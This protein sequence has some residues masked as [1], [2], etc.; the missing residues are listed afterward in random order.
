[1]TTSCWR[2]SAENK[3]SKFCGV[4]GADII[5]NN[6]LQSTSQE[7]SLDSRLTEK[8]KNYEPFFGHN[9][10]LVPSHPKPDN[11]NIN[12][13]NNNNN[14]NIDDDINNDNDNESHK[15]INSALS[16]DEE[17]L[18]TLNSAQPKLPILGTSLVKEQQIN[19]LTEYLETKNAINAEM[20]FVNIDS[21]KSKSIIFP[22][23]TKEILT[24]RNDSYGRYR[25]KRINNFDT[26]IDE[27]DSS[28]V[29]TWYP[30]GSKPG[31]GLNYTQNNNQDINNNNDVMENFD[32][33]SIAG[34]S[35][36][37]IIE[38]KYNIFNNTSNN[39][40]NIVNVEDY[41]NVY[42][43]VGD[44]YTKNY[45]YLNREPD[46]NAIYGNNTTE[47]RPKGEKQGWF[48]GSGSKSAL[49]GADGNNN[50]DGGAARVRTGSLGKRDKPRD[51]ELYFWG[52]LQV[53]L[54]KIIFYILFIEFVILILF[55]LI[56]F[57]I[58]L[59]II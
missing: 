38:S 45:Y 18:P 31:I 59:I 27:R 23:V 30:P 41:L 34:N 12:N 48:W 5:L 4:C 43:S 29:Q 51:N 58:N 47:L 11:N 32:N 56:S 39:T 9:A 35:L 13:N 10:P 14:N 37:S 3:N 49:P 33:I 50:D 55:I 15:D 19:L 46:G 2:C 25:S 20:A 40:K 16:F 28:K 42:E 44:M 57:F 52:G 8:I 54:L 17:S 24:P 6:K 21:L 22:P 7:E 1:M 26:I 36:D 53:G